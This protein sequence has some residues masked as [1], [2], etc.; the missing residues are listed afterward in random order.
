MTVENV[1]FGNSI[2]R[3]NLL[4]TFCSKIM[5]YRGIGSGVRRALVAQP[6]LELTNDTNRE[7]F[8]ATIP[9]PTE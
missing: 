5:K 7:L 3:N 6:N 9:R 4:T 1:K 8:I 2:I